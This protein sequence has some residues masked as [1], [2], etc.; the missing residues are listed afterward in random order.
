MG[1]LH[2]N[3]QA[4]LSCRHSVRT[5]EQCDTRLF[6]G[7]LTECIKSGAPRKDCYA[8]AKAYYDGVS[9][10]GGSAWDSAMSKKE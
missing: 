2:Y 10:F 4:D 3:Q 7:V 1:G 6:Q 9:F 8:F 5:K